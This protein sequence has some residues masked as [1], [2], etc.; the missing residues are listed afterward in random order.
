MTEPRREFLP[1]DAGMPGEPPP[2]KFTTEGPDPS[3]TWTP[4]ALFG[5]LILLAVTVTICLLVLAWAGVI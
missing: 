1:P 3:E 5:G 4:G 2:P